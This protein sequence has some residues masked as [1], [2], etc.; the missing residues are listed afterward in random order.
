MVH[1]SGVR[2][3]YLD[4]LTALV[5]TANEKESLEG[6]MKAMAMLAQELGIIIHFVSHLATP[7]GTP[8]EEGGRV[9]I[10]HF[11]GSRAIGFWS[12]FMF[13]LERNQQHEDERWRSITLFRV[14]KDRFTGRSTGKVIHLGYDSTKGRLFETE[15][16]GDE[17]GPSHGFQNETVKLEPRWSDDIPF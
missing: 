15:P 10:R 6:I 16:P 7:D 1:D 14:L 17:A 3:F 2:I 13:G 4:H 12:F 5:D 9:A 11:K 8:H